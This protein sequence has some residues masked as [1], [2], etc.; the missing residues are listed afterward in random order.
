MPRVLYSAEAIRERVR[1]IGR[2]ITEDYRDRQLDVV[3][4]VNGASVFCAD[5]IRQIGVPVRLHTLAFSSYAGAP[6]SGEVRVTLDIEEPLQDR[7]VLIV[8]G[9]IVSGRTPRYVLDILKSRKPASI[10]LCA[11]ATKPRL[12]A[13][14]LNINYT[15][16]ELTDEML[17]GYGV[18]KGVE[19][20]SP[21]LLDAARP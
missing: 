1:S 21:D 16:F 17:V 5:L 12:L 20:A 2:S 19:R 15:G 8:E 4:L 3:C 6:S 9:V 10:A 7:H 13:V 18:G 14:E 11:L